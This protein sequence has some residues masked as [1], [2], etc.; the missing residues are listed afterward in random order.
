[1]L[2][3][4]LDGLVVLAVLAIAVPAVLIARGERDS[5][6]RVPRKLTPKQAVDAAWLERVRGAGL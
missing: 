3:Y 2:D 6:P 4:V 5:R 1:M